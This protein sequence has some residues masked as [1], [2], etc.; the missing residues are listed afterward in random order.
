MYRQVVPGGT[1]PLSAR[2]R[3]PA[4]INVGFQHYFGDHKRLQS[5]KIRLLRKQKQQ[6]RSGSATDV[7]HRGPY[8]PLI[9]G[10]RSEVD[11]K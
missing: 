10:A 7:V 2:L 11:D 6:K 3:M 9:S 4:E 5:R 8:Q 1:L